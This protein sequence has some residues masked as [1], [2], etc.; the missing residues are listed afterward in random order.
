[1]ETFVG[2]TLD[3]VLRTYIDTS[4]YDSKYI[5]YKKPSGVSGI[6]N[7]NTC[8][9]DNTCLRFTTNSNTLN[10]AGTWFLQA[11]VEHGS[12]KLH[13]KWTQLKVLTPLHT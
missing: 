4:I 13:G 1:M 3:I 7:A 6:W 8:G 11:Y 10:E 9:A 2:D 5:K 12:E